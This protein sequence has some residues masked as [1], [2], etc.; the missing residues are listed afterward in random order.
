MM[1]VSSF[2][3]FLFLF[4]FHLYYYTQVCLEIKV[5]LSPNNVCPFVFAVFF[6]LEIHNSEKYVVNTEASSIGFSPE[7]EE[8]DHE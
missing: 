6:F 3:I 5:N 1:N 2:T 4:Y 8:Q 7:S